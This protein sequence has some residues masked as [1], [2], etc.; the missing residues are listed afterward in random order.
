MGREEA[1]AFLKREAGKSFEPRLVDA[2]LRYYERA[3]PAQLELGA[4]V[5]AQSPEE[6]PAPK[7][8]VA[9]RIA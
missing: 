3:Y 9:L 2:F 5:S 7:T 6:T 8:P 4:L 1:I